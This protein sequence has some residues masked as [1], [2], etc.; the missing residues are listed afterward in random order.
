[1]EHIDARR[2]PTLWSVAWPVAAMGWLRTGYLLT[3]SWFVGRLGDDALAAIGGAAFAW[4]MLLLLAELPGVGVHALVAQHVG[5]ERL[6]R[7]R[8]TFAQGLWLGV[9]CGVGRLQGNGSRVGFP[10]TSRSSP[11]G[12]AFCSAGGSSSSA[13]L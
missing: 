2:R 3:D 1:M 9:G 12:F 11:S 4:W 7:V 8:G 13:K 10:F 6:D 5:A